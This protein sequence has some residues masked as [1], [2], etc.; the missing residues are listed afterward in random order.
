MGIFAERLRRCIRESGQSDAE[1]ARRLGLQPQRL[2]NYLNGKSQPDIEMIAR[3]CTTLSVSPNFLFG[4]PTPGAD[5]S[6]QTLL[7][8]SILGQL[9]ALGPAKLKLVRDIV[10]R[11]GAFD[12][13]DDK[14]W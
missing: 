1:A 13:S 7:I 4:F 10:G 6:D 9:E 3:I 8:E 2:S 12:Y 5:Q 11:I 14:G